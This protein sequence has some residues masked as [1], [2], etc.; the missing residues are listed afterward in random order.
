MRTIGRKF[1]LAE[2]SDVCHAQST[3]YKKQLQ[4]EVRACAWYADE[5]CSYIS[6]T[7]VNN[8]ILSNLRQ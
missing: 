1:P 4:A 7:N 8:Q 3:Q 2:I 5:S 6:C